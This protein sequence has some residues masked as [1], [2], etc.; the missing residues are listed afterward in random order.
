MKKYITGTSWLNM[1]KVRRKKIQLGIANSSV[2]FIGF[3]IH[4]F[5]CCGSYFIIDKHS[6]SNCIS[7]FGLAV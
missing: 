1:Y 4:L 2:N 5:L 6:V 7:G 3:K